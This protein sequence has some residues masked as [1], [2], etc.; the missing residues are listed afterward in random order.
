[1][2]LG[3][4]FDN[5]LEFIASKAGLIADPLIKT[6]IAF[7]MG[8]SIM[9]AVEVGVFEA[10]NKKSL[11]QQQVAEA[12]KTNT[13]ATGMLLNAMV[14]C[15]Y[16]NFESKNQ[17]Y[18]LT[19]STEKW[20]VR[21]SPH[22][23]CDKLA[24]QN[25]E[26]NYL[27]QLVPYVKT[28]QAVDLHQHNQADVWLSYQKAMADIGKLAL[29]EV[30]RRIPIPKHAKTMLDIGGSGGTYSAAFVKS[31]PNLNSVILELP[32]AVLF[33]EPLIAS[34]QLPKDKLSI[35]AGNVLMDD[36][37]EDLYDFIFLGNV[38]HHLT[39]EQNQLLAFKVHRAL[40]ANG[41]FCILEPTR[42]PIAS[43]KSQFGSLLDLYFGLT[44]QSGTWS[45]VE[46]SEWMRIAHLKVGRQI[47]LRTAPGVA[48]IHGKK[49][50]SF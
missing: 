39:E 21:S 41:V 10:L 24:F 44:S 22:S 34:H 49:V 35:R 4:N 6:Q 16:L 19:A 32:Q 3:L 14:S 9:A 46:I 47:S 43:K 12:C 17:S 26:W 7:T 30:N 37:G 23:I 2:H 1:M 33:A 11:T 13:K 5:P 50:G 27:N 36:L 48:L 15:E 18:T 38:A 28:G 8:K 45:A 29:N 40:K 20:L 25:H 42:T 31:R